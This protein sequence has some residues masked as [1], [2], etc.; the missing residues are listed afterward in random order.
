[1]GGRGKVWVGEG[2]GEVSVRERD[3]GIGV[4]ERT[5]DCVGLF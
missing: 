4:K 5:V 3:T 2:S 1:M